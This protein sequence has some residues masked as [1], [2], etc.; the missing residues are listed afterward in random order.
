MGR[1][2]N[3]LGSYGNQRLTKPLWMCPEWSLLYTGVQVLSVMTRKKPHVTRRGGLPPAASGKLAISVNLGFVQIGPIQFHRPSRAEAIRIA[4]VALTAAVV[5]PCA[6]YWVFL[7]PQMNK[8]RTFMERGDYTQAAHTIETIV[9]HWLI[10]MPFVASVAA[11]ADFGA[12]LASGER[13]T[14]L[15]PELALLSERY[16][17]EPNV[18]FFEGLKSLYVEKDIRQALSQFVE[19]ADRDPK[20]VEALFQAAE[21]DITLAYEMLENGNESQ[22]HSAAADAQKLIDRGVFYAPFAKKLPRYADTIGDLYDLRGDSQRAYDI[23][24]D[25]APTQ[26]LSALQAAFASW[27][28]P[29]ESIAIKYALENL[30]AASDKIGKESDIE[31]WLLRTSANGGLVSVHTRAEKHCLV[32]L[33]VAVS[34]SLQSIA[35]SS[36]RTDDA[37]RV[38]KPALTRACDEG[39]VATR[40][41]EI[42]CVQ[43]LTAQRAISKADLRWP[44]LQQW[45]QL[46]LACS[47]A[48]QPLPVLSM[49]DSTPAL[50]RTS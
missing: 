19:A 31:G 26:A 21:L 46:G 7:K 42:V 30:E 22:A 32:E 39:A 41:R 16:P 27:R 50:Q 10:R 18:L 14:N 38:V 45:K 47:G 9:P 6:G 20:H 40:N 1:I 34:V 12:K 8:A 17:N 49:A 33:A 37:E 35:A 13:I 2:H 11:Q 24:A 23:Y 48:L 36:S 44:V 25:L 28:L 43:V 3:D 29:P 15:L 5:L 4:V